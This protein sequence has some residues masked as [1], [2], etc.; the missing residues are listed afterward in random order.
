MRKTLGAAAFGAVA[1]LAWAANLFRR[2]EEYAF[3]ISGEIYSDEGCPLAGAHVVVEVCADYGTL[4]GKV[5]QRV[6]K[7]HLRTDESGRY[8]GEIK[9]KYRPSPGILSSFM[10][11]SF[12]ID[13]FALD[14]EPGRFVSAS[15]RA[16]LR[17]GG[18]FANGW[19]SQDDAPPEL[20]RPGYRPGPNAQMNPT[21]WDGKTRIKVD[22]RTTPDL[23]STTPEV[24]LIVASGEGLAGWMLVYQTQWGNKEATISASGFLVHKPEHR[25][26]MIFHVPPVEGAVRRDVF[27]YAFRVTQPP[28]PSCVSP[29]GGITFPQIFPHPKNTA[30]CPNVID[31]DTWSRHQAVVAQSFAGDKGGGWRLGFPESAHG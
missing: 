2:A 12:L 21:L 8:S 1:T 30:Y 22:Y 14:H 11:F 5:S 6:S 16:I 15:S 19:I 28:D 18:P 7:F 26:G 9:G 10:G 13:A 31:K 29:V 23:M 17:Y 3:P 24:P 25:I 27:L 20:Y 4:G